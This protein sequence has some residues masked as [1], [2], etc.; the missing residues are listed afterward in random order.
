MSQ[1]VNKPTEPET[2]LNHLPNI[3]DDL[4]PQSGNPASQI[5]NPINQQPFNSAPQTSVTTHKSS[6]KRSLSESNGN[7]Q[8]Q[9]QPNKRQRQNENSLIQI[10][11]GTNNL[12]QNTLSTNS[13]EFSQTIQNNPNQNILSTHYAQSLQTIQNNQTQMDNTNSALPSSNPIQSHK[14]RNH[15]NRYNN[16][17]HNYS[18]LISNMHYGDNNHNISSSNLIQDNENK[19]NHNISPSQKEYR[20]LREFS[21]W[22]APVF[23]IKVKCMIKKDEQL[24]HKKSLWGYVIVMDDEKT[25]KRINFWGEYYTEI[26]K[27]HKMGI[28]EIFGLQ[29]VPSN[30]KFQ[31]YGPFDFQWNP[32]TKIKPLVTQSDDVLT[33]LTQKWNFIDS[34]K[35]I[36]EKEPNEIFDVI[37]VVRKSFNVRTVKTRHNKMT[38]VRTVELFDP[39]S[40][41]EASLWGKA[42]DL[43]FEKYQTITLKNCKKGDYNGTSIIVLG[44]VNPAPICDR[45]K[46]L[47]N[48]VTIKGDAMDN[49]C[50]RLP[51]I[52]HGIYDDYTDVA[53]IPMEIAKEMS[54]DYEKNQMLPNRRLFKV[55]GLIKDIKGHRLFHNQANKTFWNL[56]I[57]IKDIESNITITAICFEAVA[58]EITGY[59]GIEASE[60]RNDDPAEFANIMTQII[61]NKKE[62]QFSVRCK[63]NNYQDTKTLIYIIDEVE[64]C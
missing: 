29:T 35:A 48:W 41:I 31:Q 46:N 54:D 61:E 52:S 59:S 12:I 39:T 9:T 18:P 38:K 4:Y 24:T 2:I 26:H 57:N 62:R 17:N 34:I 49:F 14:N 51:N 7:I 64:D 21:R 6:R 40:M 13:A 44:F 1:E 63:E 30:E 32:N 27:I 16:H 53:C 3:K 23:T 56:R 58:K 19:N 28:Y 22:D 36:P 5:E 50:E 25:E 55:Q 60:L 8:A 11:P 45:A 37:A 43:L 33:T 42:T 15:N 20:P 47:R 10:R